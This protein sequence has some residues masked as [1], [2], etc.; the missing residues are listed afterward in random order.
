MAFGFSCSDFPSFSSTYSLSTSFH[1]VPT[2][3]SVSRLP[4]PERR[5]KLWPQAERL[6]AQVLL[7][8]EQTLPP[9]PWGTPGVRTPAS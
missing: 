4:F 2:S 8:R 1:R 5:V 6:G 9:E 7:C 3:S